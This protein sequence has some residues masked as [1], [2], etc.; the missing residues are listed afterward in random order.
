MRD[1]RIR[2]SVSVVGIY[3]AKYPQRLVLGVEHL[4]FIPLIEVRSLIGLRTMAA[5]RITCT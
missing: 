5:E 4:G 2:L 1:R 3:V